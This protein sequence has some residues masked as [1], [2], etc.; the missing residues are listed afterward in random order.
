MTP[1]FFPAMAQKRGPFLQRTVPTVS[2]ADHPSAYWN[3]DLHWT[4]QVTNN[5][6]ITECNGAFSVLLLLGEV[7]W[8]LFSIWHIWPLLPFLGLCDAKILWL[9]SFVLVSVSF[10]GSSLLSFSYAW[11]FL[12]I[13]CRDGFSSHTTFPGVSHPLQV[14]DSL[15]FGLRPALELQ[16][17]ATPCPLAVFTWISSEIPQA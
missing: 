11:V 1:H 16:T 9:S 14:C 8:L 4:P 15:V 6:L 5:F 10:V 17:Q 7:Q 12:R 3:L 2:S 13:L